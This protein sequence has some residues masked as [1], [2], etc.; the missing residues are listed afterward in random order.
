MVTIANI[1]SFNFEIFQELQYIFPA[2]IEHIFGFRSGMD[3]GFLYLDK[4]LQVKEF[5]SLRRFLMPD[6][7]IL[8]LVHKFI[9][10]ISP[11][12]EFPLSCIPVSFLVFKHIIHAKKIHPANNGANITNCCN[13]YF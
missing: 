11:K 4:E 10:E 1:N 7:P 6:G 9:E 5:E 2:L 8:K 13:P 12:F 3:W